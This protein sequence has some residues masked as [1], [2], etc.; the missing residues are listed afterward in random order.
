MPDGIDDLPKGCFSHCEKLQEVTAGKGLSVMSD[1]S[2][3]GC[4]ALEK[5]DFR[6]AKVL[7]HIHDLAFLDCSQVKAV[8]CRED[9]AALL[10]KH[11]RPE[12]LV[13][14]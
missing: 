6:P 8:L 10:R 12:I 1:R 9:Q 4:T 14:S 2:F 11:F 13:I 5:L 3:N 7:Y